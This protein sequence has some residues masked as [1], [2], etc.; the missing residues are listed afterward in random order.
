MSINEN[1]S[2][3]N[4][5]ILIFIVAQIY[6]QLQRDK[7]SRAMSDNL[8]GMLQSVKNI[9]GINTSRIEELERKLN[10]RS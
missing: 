10:K 6:F 7:Y 1:V 9:T 4:F 2:L 3:M 5:T 8:I